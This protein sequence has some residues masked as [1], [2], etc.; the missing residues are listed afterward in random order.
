MDFGVVVASILLIRCCTKNISTKHSIIQQSES[1]SLSQD[2]GF[3]RIRKM[4]PV[5]EGSIKLRQIPVDSKK[6]GR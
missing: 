4:F 2:N 5:N 6:R 3:S 1:Y